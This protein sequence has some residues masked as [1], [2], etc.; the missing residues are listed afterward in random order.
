MKK[1]VIAAGT[2]FLGTVLIDFFKESY[3][4]I[5]VLTRGKS[6]QKNNIEYGNCK[7]E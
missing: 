4:E 7:E 6:E 5:I 1:M 3:A 2:G